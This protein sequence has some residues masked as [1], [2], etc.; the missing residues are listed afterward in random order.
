MHYTQTRQFVERFLGVAEDWLDRAYA[1]SNHLTG[2]TTN[3]HRWVLAFILDNYKYH[4]QRLRQHAEQILN[5]L[6]QAID[7]GFPGDLN[8]DRVDL[9]YNLQRLREQ[10]PEIYFVDYD[11]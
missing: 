9:P 5:D 4:G 11:E 1:I 10:I 8:I 3:L 6:E 7:S 2:H